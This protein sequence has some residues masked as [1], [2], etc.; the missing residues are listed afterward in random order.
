LVSEELPKRKRRMK[1]E[2]ET[3]DDGGVAIDPGEDDLE[4][5]TEDEDQPQTGRKKGKITAKQRRYERAM[6]MLE[7]SKNP[8]GLSNLFALTSIGEGVRVFNGDRL[9]FSGSWK[10]A[11]GK[12]KAR[13]IIEFAL[14]AGWKQ[15]YLFKEDGRSFNQEAASVIQQE[16]MAARL[17][18]WDPL[19]TR[20][21]NG[22]S[23]QAVMGTPPKEVREKRYEQDPIGKRIDSY[24]SGVS[25]DLG[26]SW[27]AM[28]SSVAAEGLR[29]RRAAERQAEQAAKAEAAKPR[30]ADEQVNAPS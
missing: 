28:F 24:L 8:F 9:K 5:A 26:D 25:T 16:L 2:P 12:R 19:R 18:E 6:R 27:N 20:L 14:D 30:G 1:R 17:G 23:T 10:G 7:D 13:K 15:I 11:E 4:S 22:E 3:P 21:R 29:E